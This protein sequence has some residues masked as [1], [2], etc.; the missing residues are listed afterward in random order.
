MRTPPAQELSARPRPITVRPVHRPWSPLRAFGA[1]F[2][3]ILFALPLVFMISGSLR[4]PGLPPPASPQLVPD[5]LGL[6][7]YG[8]AFD[9]VDLGRYTVNS[10]I[11]VALVVPL[12]VVVASW[13]GFA[14]ARLGG[15]SASLLVAVSIAAL[16]VPTTALI[17]P[18][19][20]LYRFVGV[21]DTWVPLVAP[22]LLGTS[23]LFV[24]LYAVAFRRLPRDLYDACA[25]ESLGPFATWRRVAMP[26]VTP[27]TAAVAV[28]AFV[29][30]WGS[31]LEPLVYLFDP[32]LYTLPLGLRSLA[33]L[34]RSDYPVFLAGCV[35]ATAPV[36]LA[37]L[38]AQRWLPLTRKG[39]EWLAR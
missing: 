34:D 8:R 1:A 36:L 38:V 21:T 4:P 5:P 20:T 7:S 25:L 2:V 33:V 3:A 27:V 32:A 31:A 23:P 16:M 6:G 39:A 18:R 29:V 14:I 37:F 9:L 28:L 26:V 30:S 22:A 12:T 11:V 13:A 19:F 24:L 15:R 17:V 10:L 35:V